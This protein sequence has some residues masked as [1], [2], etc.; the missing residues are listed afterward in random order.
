VSVPVQ[1]YRLGESLIAVLEGKPPAG[2][3]LVE[4]VA[5]DVEPVMPAGCAAADL[6][7]SG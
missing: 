4:T 5:G 6:T 1:I 2:A 3:E 7:P